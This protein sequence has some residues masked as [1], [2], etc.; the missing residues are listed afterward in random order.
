MKVLHTTM[1]MGESNED[2]KKKLELMFTIVE[3]F[4]GSFTYHPGLISCRAIYLVIPDEHDA[5]N[6]NEDDRAMMQ[7]VVAEEIRPLT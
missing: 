2:W 3:Q 5:S 7:E 1:Q 4:G 6:V